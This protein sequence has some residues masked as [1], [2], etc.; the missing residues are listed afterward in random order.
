MDYENEISSQKTFWNGQIERLN[1]THRRFDEISRGV[2]NSKSIEEKRAIKV[3]LANE[4]EHTKI[5]QHGLELDTC[6]QEIY[7]KLE[8]EKIK[9]LKHM[10]VSIARDIKFWNYL[11]NFVKRFSGICKKFN[12]I[13]L[14]LEQL[15][16][17]SNPELWSRLSIILKKYGNKINGRAEKAT[18]SIN[19]IF[20][21]SQTTNRIFKAAKKSKEIILESVQECLVTLNLCVLKIN[22]I[23]RNHQN[24]SI[25]VQKKCK[26][27]K[28]ES[29]NVKWFKERNFELSINRKMI[30]K[31]QT[32]KKI[33]QY[34]SEKVFELS[35]MRSLLLSI[36]W[37]FRKKIS[38]TFRFFHHNYMAK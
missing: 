1:I 26:D 34:I 37:K 19:Q 7:L 18:R 30:E 27:N 13:V 33:Y 21:R 9:L 15:L 11:R 23:Y 38:S 10:R 5:I 8:I 29:I 22:T 20:N 31:M 4:I 28:N 32:V 2:V 17:T 3:H 24:R 14:D 12:N 36:N 25:H 16:S 6:W 35:S